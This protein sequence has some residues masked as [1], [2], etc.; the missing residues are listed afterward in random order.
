MRRIL[1]LVTAL[2]IC[3]MGA[4]AQPPTP[5]SAQPD[6]L[7]YTLSTA[8]LVYFVRNRD[9][10]RL[11]PVR[12]FV[13]HSE[14]WTD[15]GNSRLRVAT[16]DAC[17]DLLRCL[18]GDTVDLS[19]DGR[20][21]AIGGRARSA[22]TLANRDFLLHLPDKKLKPGVQWTD[23]VVMAVPGVAG[24]TT[25]EQRWSYHVVRLVDTLGTRVAEVVGDG[26]THF[27]EGFVVDTASRRAGW[28]TVGG[29]M[30][31]AFMFDMKK[32]RLLGHVLS[33]DLSGW[34]AWPRVDGGMDTLPAGLRVRVGKELIPAP[35]A[36]L[37]TRALPGRD[38][39][40]TL[41]SAR[42]V[43]YLHTVRRSD[44]EIEG[45]MARTDGWV[46]TASER[47]HDG[48]PSTFHEVW[49]DAPKGDST[50]RDI[51]QRGDSL[52][53]RKDGRDTVIAIPEVT[54]AIADVSMHEFL[55]PVLL[56]I[57]RDSA[58]HPLAV[59]RPYYRRWEIFRARLWPVGGVYM[60]VL[61]AGPRDAPLV[62]VVSKDGDLLMASRSGPGA[63][64]RMPQPGTPR[65]GTLQSAI[66]LMKPP[67][68]TRAGT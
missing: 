2:A 61:A 65:A 53:V 49:T 5:Y 50:V 59:Y 39:S 15:M 28:I 7:Y 40:W 66:Q 58:E 64:V 27:H 67:N 37:L 57:P 22:D 12:R 4:A 9:T 13:V 44:G 24:G 48:R 23:S 31:Q 54:W 43:L 16:R 51:E 62:L 33:A 35:R 68:G 17:V 55:I 41:D 34:G 6:T 19:P 42:Q 1:A 38:S 46:H 29:T 14:L 18:H 45:G 52:L 8:R 56:T 3:G 11:P 10:L 21:L 63:F 36:A 30:R 26:A 32:G 20:L 25:N 60:V 47:F